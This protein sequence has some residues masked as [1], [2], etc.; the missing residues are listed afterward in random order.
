MTY[1]VCESRLQFETR[2]DHIKEKGVTKTK[3]R[4]IV[5]ETDFPFHKIQGRLILRK[6][7][8]MIYYP[9]G[10]YETVEQYFTYDF[11]SFIGDVGG[12]LVDKIP[13][14]KASLLQTFLSFYLNSD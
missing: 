4:D 1:T 7:E 10:N 8:F 14:V 3:E 2:F 11:G 6:V 5:S 12:Y 13:C 9:R